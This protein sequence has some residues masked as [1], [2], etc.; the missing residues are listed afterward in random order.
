MIEGPAIG[1]GHG[2]DE[3]RMHVAKG[4]GVGGDHE[5]VEFGHFLLVGFWVLRVVGPAWRGC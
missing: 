4:E 3:A 2:G 5:V 1:P